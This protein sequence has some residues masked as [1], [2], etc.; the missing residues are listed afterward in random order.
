MHHP[1]VVIGYLS[2]I[3]EKNKK[4]RFDDFKASIDSLHKLNRYEIIS[5]DNASVDEA[6]A[7]I[8]QSQCFS[9]RFFLEKNLYDIALFFFTMKYAIANNKKYVAFLY[10]DFIISDDKIESCIKFLD[11]NNDV[12]CVRIPAYK[13]DDQYY[14][15]DKTPKSINPDSV[16]HNNCI[17]SQKL[18]WDGPID[19]DGNIFWTNNWH[20]TSRPSIWRVSIISKF[21]EDDRI[22]VLQ[23]FEKKAGD[24]FASMR[25]KVGV[26]DGGM[27]KT[28]DTR[29]SARYQESNEHNSKKI[30]L[31]E[32]NKSFHSLL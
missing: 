32:L 24:I 6:K 11:H 5:I 29:K 3:T 23:E 18:T 30:E 19:V 28:T 17:T 31:A 27:M 9:K 25:M 13:K 14:D 12:G 26:L 22:P 1:D 2:F 4:L 20:Y 21:F 16:R 10:D 7:V 8:E 15:C